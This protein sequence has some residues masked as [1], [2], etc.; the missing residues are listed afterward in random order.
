MN[1]F[2]VQHAAGP[3]PE[4]ERCED[5]TLYWTLSIYVTPDR[6]PAALRE[7]LK[8]ANKHAVQAGYLDTEGLRDAIDPL[9]NDIADRERLSHVDDYL[10]D[11][12]SPRQGEAI[13]ITIPDAI[14][15]TTEGTVFRAELGKPVTRTLRC[16]RFWYV[17]L[18]GALSY[19]LSFTLRYAHT[20][21]DFY[22][23]SMLQKVVAPKEFTVSG[24]AGTGTIDGAAAGVK[25]FPVENVNVRSQSSGFTPLPFWQF[26]RSTFDQHAHHLFEHFGVSLGAG[27]NGAYFRALVASDPFIEIPRLTMPRTRF[28]FIF[29]DQTFVRDLLPRSADGKRLAR[30]D[31]VKDA[32]YDC[33]KIW[34]Q[35]Q[36]SAANLA[37]GATRTAPTVVM[38]REFLDQLETECPDRLRYLFL[39]GF[40]QNIID[41]VNQEA[42]E[43]LD[44]TDPIYPKT[45]EQEEE[46]FFV[47]FA[48]PRA[49]IQF[50]PASRSLEIGNDYIGTCP[51]AFLIHVTALHN[52]YIIREYEQSVEDLIK[53]IG[54]LNAKR[55]L[56]RAAQRFYDFRTREFTNYRKFRYT[57]IFRYDTEADV[58]TEVE[59]RRGSLRKD[60]YL[61]SIVSNL[62][63]QTRDLEGRLRSSEDRQLT[64][65]VAGVGIFSIL[66]VVLQILD[67]FENHIG[68]PRVNKVFFGIDFG[69]L[70]NIDSVAGLLIH[71]TGLVLVILAL[72]FI[73][74]YAVKPL[75]LRVVGLFTRAD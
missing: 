36:I 12:P 63:A 43:V 54:Q 21:A 24:P 48:N 5:K 59:R 30:R 51:Y 53:T 4:W 55:Q 27:H 47:R 20:A 18:N 75:F 67:Y 57:N 46:N 15:W 49:L 19:H 22:F 26:V 37:A 29:N 42:S 64:S 65:L 62:E 13:D 35:E 45:P 11:V 31:I 8:P 34:V 6:I 32:D 70:T 56:G 16:R 68:E 10:L 2:S 38:S 60:Q 50:V 3:L 74:F 7:R 71:F 40:N 73:Y 14:T 61:E 39:A 28:L 23:I 72:L 17:H 66:Q 69:K 25:L 58:F 52:E 1:E 33:F 44:S 9:F 41:F